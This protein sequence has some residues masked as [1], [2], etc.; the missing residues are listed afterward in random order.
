MIAVYH[1]PQVARYQ[2]LRNNPMFLYYLT[3][4]VITFL[5]ALIAGI[6]LYRYQEK[7]TVIK[8]IGIM[9]SISFLC[10][11][12]Q[13]IFLSLKFYSLINITSSI[14]DLS[15]IVLIGSIFNDQTRSKHRQLIF[16]ITIIY[17]IGSIL[18]LALLQKGG[19]ASYN[20]LGVSFILIFYSIYYFYRLMVDLPTMH[21]HR[22]PMFWFNSAFLIFSAG[23]IFLFAFT[24]YLIHVLK[25]D[26]QNYWSFHNGLF[27]F[28]QFIILIGISYDLKSSK[29][30]S[31]S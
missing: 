3:F 4:F 21:V 20:K 24:D 22:L 5:S 11:I 2:L 15:V 1:V 26:L 9:F 13:F 19:N 30:A 16:G 25:D 28:H 14:Y 17:L 10:N 12:L 8:L 7:D 29:M 27:I 31:K 18:N 6:S 23:T